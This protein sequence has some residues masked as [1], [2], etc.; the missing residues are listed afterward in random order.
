MPKD[1]PIVA[2]QITEA[3]RNGDVKGLAK[4]T[5]ESESNARR[6]AQHARQQGKVDRDVE[7]VR[8]FVDGQSKKQIAT[9]DG[10]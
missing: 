9:A 1:L 7:I 5:G 8:R 2:K 3:E 10:Q 6:K 4:T